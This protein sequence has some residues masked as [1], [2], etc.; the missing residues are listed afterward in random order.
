MYW[1]D[2]EKDEWV[3][4]LMLD[5]GVQDII[6]VEKFDNISEIFWIMHIC[7]KSLHGQFLRLTNIY[8]DLLAI[9]ALMVIFSLQLNQKFHRNCKKK[10]SQD[11]LS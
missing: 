1:P 2:V 6:I 11:R 9:V 4:L 8:V 3:T 7:V 5:Q 10:F